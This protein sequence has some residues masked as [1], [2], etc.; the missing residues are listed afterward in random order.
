[1]IST[2]NEQPI[3]QPLAGVKSD[4]GITALLAHRCRLTIRDV[5]G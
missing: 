3:K 5:E 4:E 2:R 1:M